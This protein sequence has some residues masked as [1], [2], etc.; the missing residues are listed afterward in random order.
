MID[1]DFED[2][3][4]EECL[5]HGKIDN[6]EVIKKEAGIEVLVKFSNAQSANI[7]VNEFEGRIFQSKQIS[8]SIE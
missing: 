4:R 8:A 2:D 1:D 7:A 3:I 6:L 5:K